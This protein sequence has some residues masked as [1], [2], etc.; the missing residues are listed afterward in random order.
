MKNG[1]KFAKHKHIWKYNKIDTGVRICEA[2]IPTIP[3]C[4]EVQWKNNEGAWVLGEPPT[5]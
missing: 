1:I 3:S 2:P 5:N 4:G